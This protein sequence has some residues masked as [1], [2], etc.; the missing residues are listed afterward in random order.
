MSMIYGDENSAYELLY[1]G[2]QDSAID[3]VQS[4]ISSL[5]D[6]GISLSTSF[7]ESTKHLFNRVASH[8]VVR[9]ARRV[10]AGVQAYSAGNNITVM[11]T[12][13][14]FQTA[15]PANRRWVTANPY[16]REL[17]GDQ[18]ISGYGDNLKLS[19]PGYTGLD[20]RDY[21]IATNHMV[22]VD[23]EVGR[24]EIHHFDTEPKKDELMPSQSEIFDIQRNFTNFR[25][26]HKKAVEEG[27]ED[28]TDEFGELL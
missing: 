12:A 11:N 18:V 13:L 21:R 28:I 24:Y 25:R 6:A 23:E 1:G 7:I 22:M 15:K 4:R 20:V 8:D 19:Q 27:G 5:A 9:Q 10:V 2:I 3:A 14:D 16:F 26:L 17:L